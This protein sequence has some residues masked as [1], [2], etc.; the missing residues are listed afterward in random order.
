LDEQDINH[1]NRLITS[2]ENEAVIK[3]AQQRKASNWMD[4]L[5]N[6]TRPERTYTNVPQ[7]VP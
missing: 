1:L 3:G 5:L 7:T 6:S 4:S 2:N